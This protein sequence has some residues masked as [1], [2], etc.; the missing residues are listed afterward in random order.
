MGQQCPGLISP[1]E[2]KS[3]VSRRETEAALRI[4]L[5]S[6]QPL[7]AE[8]MFTDQKLPRVALVMPLPRDTRNP[9][10]I[11][12]AVVY[13]IDLRRFVKQA[14][15]QESLGPLDIELF[16][17][18]EHWNSTP[19]R[20]EYLVYDTGDESIEGL[21]EDEQVP[22]AEHQVD[23][24][25][26]RWYLVASLPEYDELGGARLLPKLV[27]LA[28]T[29]FTLLL[30]SL[31]IGLHITRRQQERLKVSSEQQHALLN[32]LLDI[33]WL[34]DPEGRIIVANQAYA[35]AA[36]MSQEELAGKV[37]TDI[38]PE[39]LARN[40]M[41]GDKQVR[42][43]L[44]PKRT[45]ELF[46]DRHG[47]KHW[48]DTIKT[49]VI[50][51]WGRFLGTVGTARDIT[52]RKRIEGE[53][54]LAARV[55]ESAVEGIAITDPHL[56]IQRVNQTFCQLSDLS[57]DA[58]LG[59]PL[60]K[61]AM[62]QTNRHFY[63][64]LWRTLRREHHWQGEIWYR[65]RED[66]RAIWL[67]LAAQHDRQGRL[68]HYIAMCIDVTERKLS[69]DR[70][71]HLAYHD[72]LTG[73]FNRTVLF[74]RLEQAI[75]RARRV[76]TPV[77]VLFIDLDRFKEV[78]DTYG[79]H[80]GDELLRQVAG[81]LRNNLRREDTLVR[82]GGDEFVVLLEHQSDRQE[83]DKVR[84]KLQQQ[85]EIPFDCEGEILEIGAS[86]GVSLFPD[87]G[88]DAD[89]LLRRADDAM[90]RQKNGDRPAQAE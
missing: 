69:E 68:I 45:E 10:S 77:G 57:E 59:Q 20:A 32:N 64:Q 53:L 56:R 36:G 72:P 60:F 40:Y 19:Y 84:I 48:I 58:L 81:R 67:H 27:W 85:F 31:V 7:L 80:L 18:R 1:V 47:H 5:A 28:G 39:A 9:R 17:H 35:D 78:N 30:L 89:S 46:I 11:A 13:F 70:I 23:L 15:P 75:S 63:R 86:I 90:Y 29:G 24:A 73:C 61:L 3:L 12:Q 44:A 65:T 71:R 6:D 79:H 14:I 50:D 62:A 51:K 33:A 38:W 41:A 16:S 2:L 37:D 74:E 4:A 83:I 88:Q 87:H 42:H 25:G 52:E 26:D 22:L 55:F 21:Q 49:P 54:Q 82:Q 43:S 8:V 76:K 34:K 66:A